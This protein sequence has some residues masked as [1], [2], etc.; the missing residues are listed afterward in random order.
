M[1][2]GLV[3]GAVER[4]LLHRVLVFDSENT[5]EGVQTF[6]EPTVEGR[7]RTAKQEAVL[8]GGTC[9]DLLSRFQ[10]RPLGVMEGNGYISPLLKK[11]LMNFKAQNLKARQVILLIQ[12]SEVSEAEARELIP[13][14][15]ELEER[16]TYEPSSQRKRRVLRG[17]MWA[18]RGFE[19]A[20]NEKQLRFNPLNLPWESAK[21]P[22][23]ID[24]PFDGKKVPFRY[25]I[26]RTL[27]EEKP[28]GGNFKLLASIMTTVIANETNALGLDPRR[29]VITAHALDGPQ[30]RL[31]TLLFPYRILDRTAQAKIEADVQSAMATYEQA[32]LPTAEEWTDLKDMVTYASLQ[33]FIEK[34]PAAKVSDIGVK[35]EVASDGRIDAQRG[36]YFWRDFNSLFRRDY[37]FSNPHLGTSKK[38]L[39]VA[40]VADGMFIQELMALLKAYGIPEMNLADASTAKPIQKMLDLWARF[41]VNY[42]PDLFLENWEGREII[43][44]PA[45][46][47][48]IPGI[49]PRQIS[50]FVTNLDRAMVRKYPRV[51]L[52][53]VIL[54]LRDSVDFEI[55]QLAPS[56]FLNLRDKVNED[57]E[58]MRL[59]L[60][61]T[62]DADV[63]FETYGLGFGDTDPLVIEE[64]ALLGGLRFKGAIMRVSGNAAESGPRDLKEISFGLEQTEGDLFEFKTVQLKKLAADYPYLRENARQNLTFGHWKYRLKMMFA[65][66]F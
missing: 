23:G 59:P 45:M 63:F 58:K 16:T 29:V 50:Y 53:S 2:F 8:T 22:Q 4:P 6:L 55:T 12:E 11:L 7:Y 35:T 51:Y 65:P 40:R 54:S 24:R 38:P 47:L 66:M 46:D 61:S 19:V 20:P 36:G 14:P 28:L 33:R 56:R 41:D 26:G 57:R 49:R 43:L 10:S 31:F 52:A 5:W 34:F 13:D 25:E 64:L 32:P 48:R 3:A 30:G 39:I 62:V 27:S 17:A 37:T 9:E 60:V 21:M 1:L 44:H 15:K 18:V 42:A